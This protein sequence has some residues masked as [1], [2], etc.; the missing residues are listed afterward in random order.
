[1]VIVAVKGRVAAEQDVEHASSAPH[2]ARDVIVAC[3]HL[4]GDVVRRAGSSLHSMNTAT[5]HYL[6]QA[7]VNDFEVGI[8]RLSLEQEILWL[9]ITMY[10]VLCVAVVK[11]LQ[12]LAEDLRSLVLFEEL[13]L[14]DAIEQLAASAKSLPIN[15]K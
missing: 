15:Y 1:M 7:E 11:R 4:R 13:C 6:R 2:V 3:E 12:N 5:F 8:I 10:N 14:D 9:Q